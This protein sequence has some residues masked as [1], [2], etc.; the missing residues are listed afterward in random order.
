MP[1]LFQS[2]PKE[3]FQQQTL[4]Y[5]NSVPIRKHVTAATTDDCVVV[6]QAYNPEIAQ[7]AVSH[8]TFE[9]CSKF[10]MTRMTWIKTNYLWMMYRSEYATSKNQERILALFI[11]KEY[12][13]NSILGNGI[14]SYFYYGLDQVYG[15]EEEWKKLMDQ[16]KH[17]NTCVRVQWDPYHDPSGN[18]LP[19]VRAIQIGLKGDIVKEMLSQHKVKKIED[20]TSYVREQHEHWKQTGDLSIPVERLY[21]I[22]NE[23]IKRKLAIM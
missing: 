10:S 13:E 11:D 14:C 12:F 17:A 5:L 23:E 19:E 4:N 16:Q 22:E 9:N 21:S 3:S 1:S 7:H 8:Q 18:K 20:I 2:L 6:Y 15:S